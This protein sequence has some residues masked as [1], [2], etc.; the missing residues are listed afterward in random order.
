MKSNKIIVSLILIGCSFTVSAQVGE[1][2]KQTLWEN[3][4][5]NII[6]GNEEAAVASAED[7]LDFAT[8]FDDEVCAMFGKTSAEQ[9]THL[10]TDEG[11]TLLIAVSDPYSRMYYSEDENPEAGGLQKYVTIVIYRM[12][13][14]DYKLMRVQSAFLGGDVDYR[15]NIT[16]AAGAYE[17]EETRLSQLRKIIGYMKDGDVKN[18]KASSILTDE[19]WIE[20]GKTLL[21]DV[22]FK[23]IKADESIK[24]IF[25][26]L[27]E[28][29]EGFYTTHR[30]DRMYARLDYSGRPLSEEEL[31]YDEGFEGEENY[32]KRKELKT[33]TKVDGVDFYMRVRMTFSTDN[34]EKEL[35]LVAIYGQPQEPMADREAEYAARRAESAEMEGEYGGE[36]MEAPEFRIKEN[37]T[38]REKVWNSL[39]K[40]FQEKEVKASDG[41][42]PLAWNVD[43]VNADLDGFHY[44][45]EGEDIPF[46]TSEEFIPQMAKLLNSGVADHLATL[47]PEDLEFGNWPLMADLMNEDC[48]PGEEGSEGGEEPEES[49]EERGAEGAEYSE[50]GEEGYYDGEGGYSTSPRYAGYVLRGTFLVE[51]TIG[52]EQNHYD[53]VVSLINGEWK[54]TSAYLSVGWK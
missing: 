47:S 54:L 29:I 18:I 52:F 39:I 26:L 8:Y 48:C 42:F 22:N 31:M 24:L 19:N 43:F 34:P 10:V 45:G 28:G 7:Y 9:I 4:I 17:V 23:K 35:Q 25:E 33:T 5:T 1:K 49:E 13:G 6:D 11:E 2:E 14:N 37:T 38:D 51:K 20:I 12:V 53:L 27:H 44:G 36:M 50:E 30:I 21:P 3:H 41:H 32:R 15:K 16:A 46:L 40:A